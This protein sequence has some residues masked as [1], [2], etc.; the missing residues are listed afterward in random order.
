MFTQNSKMAVPKARVA[1][2]GL[3]RKLPITTYKTAAV[4]KSSEIA[5]N[6]L[7][8][9]DKASPKKLAAQMQRGANT[10]R[11]PW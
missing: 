8:D 1:G 2:K 5:E 10:L 3:P 6:V 11:A 9:I 7:K 4:T